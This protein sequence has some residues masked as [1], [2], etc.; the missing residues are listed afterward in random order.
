MSNEKSGQLLTVYDLDTSGIQYKQLLQ[1][2][3]Q[4]SDAG[5]LGM[6][7]TCLTS[8]SNSNDST[9][10]GRS[11]DYSPGTGSDDDNV[12]IHNEEIPDEEMIGPEH[13]ERHVGMNTGR[14][15]SD[16]VEEAPRAM[17]NLS[18]SFHERQVRHAHHHFLSIIPSHLAPTAFYVLN[19]VSTIPSA[20]SGRFLLA[21]YVEL[22]NLV[23]HA[24]VRLMHSP[25]PS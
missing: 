7:P 20:N 8:C 19:F 24:L 2:E 22:S 15:A 1:L 18:N 9:T 4:W 14:E 10:D 12:H 11:D 13:F 6:T 17:R 25:L 16:D 21:L 3:T 5:G 23:D